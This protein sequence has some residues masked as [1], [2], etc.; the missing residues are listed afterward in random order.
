[1][2]ELFT[3]CVTVLGYFKTIILWFILSWITVQ[4]KTLQN[5]FSVALLL[6]PPVASVSTVP[7]KGDECL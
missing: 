4:H 3:A 5:S 7:D 2:S 6:S 1:M